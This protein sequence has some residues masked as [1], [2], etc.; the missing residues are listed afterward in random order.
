MRL[1][2][3]DLN[4]FVVFDAIYRERSVTKVAT[5]L[6]ITQ[7]AVSNALNRLRQ[8]FDDPLF[9]HSQTGMNPTPVAEKVI[10][11]IREALH[12]L[13]NSVNTNIQFEAKES[14]K[15]FRLAMYDFTS[16]F[17]LP[18]IYAALK[19]QAPLATLSNFYISREIATEDLKA[20]R[21]DL[22]I[23]SPMVNAKDLNQ[24]PVG[25]YPYTVAMRAEHPLAKTLAQGA[26][27]TVREI[28]LEQYLASAHIYVS[29]RR[30]GRGHVD[31]ALHAAGMQRRVDARVQSYMA[32]ANLVTQ[33]DILLTAPKI[34]FADKPLITVPTPMPVEPLVCNAYWSKST[35]NDPALSWLRQLIQKLLLP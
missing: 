24:M 29:S 22:L 15:Q 25:S 26:K 13:G 1:N 33:L 19:A 4:L 31:V 30:S 16:S 34:L 18:K 35:D 32:A 27:K 21:I 12:L 11:D 17:L 2:K 20:G 6:N 28:S 10:G 14:Q 3:V 7:P 8:T 9:V 23:D 5:I